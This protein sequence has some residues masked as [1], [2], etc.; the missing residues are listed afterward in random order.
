MLLKSQQ[1]CRPSLSGGFS[2]LALLSTEATSCVLTVAA[3]YFSKEEHERDLLFQFSFCSCFWGRITRTLYGAV[4]L[5]VRV[6]AFSVPLLIN[7]FA[8]CAGHHQAHTA[9]GVPSAAPQLLLW[10]LMANLDAFILCVPLGLLFP[11]CI[12]L[13]V[14]MPNFNISFATYFPASCGHSAA[15]IWPE[16]HLVHSLGDSSSLSPH[17]TWCTEQVSA[18]SLLKYQTILALHSLSIS[19]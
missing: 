19:R 16:E 17:L 11:G 9:G 14:S 13:H 3:I 6:G 8:C 7:C 12:A 10:M 2:S 5:A 18:W 15:W 4:C 1:C